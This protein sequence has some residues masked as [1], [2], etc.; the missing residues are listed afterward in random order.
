MRSSPTRISGVR[1]S[2]QSGQSSPS[3]A[4][5]EII[6][7]IDHAAPMRGSFVSTPST[8]TRPQSAIRCP[9]ASSSNS[10]M[11]GETAA[12]PQSA[13]T[14]TRSPRSS[15]RWVPSPASQP[16]DAGE[17]ERIAGVVAVA[18]VEPAGGVPDRPRHA[19]DDDGQVAVR[20]PS[21]T[22]GCGRTCLQADEPGEAGRDPDR[23]AAVAAGRERDDARRRPRPPLPPDDP[24]GVRPCCH[25]LWVVP[26]STRAGD[27][28]AAELR[29]RGLADEHGA[30]AVADALDVEA[31][32][33]GD[34]VVERDR[35]VA[36][37]AI[38]RPGRAP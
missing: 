22:A 37:T 13:T 25:G 26:F 20:A 28:D 36:C 11:T 1:S 21:A 29:R 9:A 14:A 33:A 16:L 19:A 18:D 32:V 3:S 17:A 7:L 15:S 30:A 6:P 23:S 27:V 24:P 38:R 2:A 8:R 12:P 35:R 10:H 5:I 4:P 31:R 34:P